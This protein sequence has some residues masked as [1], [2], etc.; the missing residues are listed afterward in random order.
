MGTKKSSE[1]LRSWPPTHNA[2][3]SPASET[4]FLT[5]SSSGFVSPEM[6]LHQR[7][8]RLLKFHPRRC[9]VG[10]RLR[11]FG[12]CLTRW[13]FVGSR[14]SGSTWMEED[15]ASWE[16]ESCDPH[17]DVVGSFGLSVHHQETV[18][19]VLLRPPPEEET[20]DIGRRSII[21]TI[22]TFYIHTIYS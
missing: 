15:L 4:Q 10:L 20:H 7:W 22:C 3:L 16:C 5:S 14:C 18:V 2:I 21:N 8:K 1:T 6:I 19:Q 11:N 12:L 9:R 13:L 17:L